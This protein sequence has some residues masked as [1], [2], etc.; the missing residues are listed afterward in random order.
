MPSG[1]AAAGQIRYPELVRERLPLL[2]LVLVGFASIGAA[3]EYVAELERL[4]ARLDRVEVLDGNLITL[5]AHERGR[6]D[7]NR[8]EL[9][10]KRQKFTA[11]LETASDSDRRRLRHWL[12]MVSRADREVAVREGFRRPRAAWI[13][14]SLA[15][16][17]RAHR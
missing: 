6:L 11:R 5:W 2:G 12:R 3:R 1:Y 13:T 15:Q 9:A 14:A 10:F 8:E 16:L 7:A 17:E 4:V